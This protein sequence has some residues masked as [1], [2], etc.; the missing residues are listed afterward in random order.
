MQM[1]GSKKGEKE[2]GLEG[3]GL[4]VKTFVC[5]P[6]IFQQMGSKLFF[7]QTLNGGLF[8][9]LRFFFHPYYPL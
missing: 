3:H 4:D 1:G 2:G 6:P 5:E 7:G 8:I 9:V